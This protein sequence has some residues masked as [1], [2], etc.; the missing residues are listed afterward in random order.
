MSIEIQEL[1]HGRLEIRIDGEKYREIHRSI[2]GHKID[3]TTLDLPACFDELEYRR[4]KNYVLWRLS[5]QSY[6]SEQIV[7]LLRERLVQKKTIKKTIE[8][9]MQMGLF[10][11]R[12]WLQ[13]FLSREQKKHSLRALSVK[14]R[15]KGLS[16]ETLEGIGEEWNNPE[17]ELEA[18]K[19]L[20]KTRYRSVDMSSYK[21]RQKVINALLRRG[22]SWELIQS[23]LVI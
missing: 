18:I 8:E 4:A 16:E 1:G 13:S 21:D 12:A 23:S 7:K 9:C 22:Y 3:F 14:L 10:D 11:D 5:V 15:S 2:F 20:C 17:K 6:H 19:T